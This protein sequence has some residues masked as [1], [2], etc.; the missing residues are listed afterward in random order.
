MWWHAGTTIG[1]LQRALARRGKTLSAHPS[2]LSATLGGWIASKSHGTGGSLWVPATARIVVDTP[3]EKNVVLSSKDR[4]TESMIIR[5]VEVTPVDNVVVERQVAYLENEVAVREHLFDAQTYLRAVFVD[6]LSILC[7]KWVPHKDQS[8]APMCADV[9]PL[10]L[11]TLLPAW[12]R[13]N[14]KTESWKRRMTLRSA[15]N[16]G[17]DPPFLLFTSAMMTRTNFEIFVTE[18][19][20][21][22]LIWSICKGFRELFASRKIR[23]RM[24][25]RFGKG[26]QFLDFALTGKTSPVFER[27]RE[28]YGHNVVFHLHP[29]KAQVPHSGK[30]S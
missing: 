10:W 22:R 11:M 8:E 13:C 23:G 6:K 1:D 12:S 18:P 4:V 29:G 21:P 16:F 25:L 24:E 28:I 30:S 15:N 7:I 9:P 27:L 17:P 20:T 2:I 5:E 3:L 19:T 26:K 14:L